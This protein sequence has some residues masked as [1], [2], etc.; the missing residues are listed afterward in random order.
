MFLM[1]FQ[2]SKL[3][4]FISTLVFAFAPAV[5]VAIAFIIGHFQSGDSE[6][7]DFPLQVLQG[8]SGLTPR[9]ESRSKL[10][11]LGFRLQGG[12]VCSLEMDLRLEPYNSP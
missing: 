3:N 7:D 12:A 4:Y 1:P 6:F 5:G 9:L 8:E 2:T 11:Q 10:Q